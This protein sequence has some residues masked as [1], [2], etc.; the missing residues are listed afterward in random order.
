MSLQRDHG[1]SEERGRRTGFLYSKAFLEDLAGT[2][3][4]ALHPRF[5]EMLRYLEQVKPAGL[6]PGRQHIDPVDFPQFLSLIN[7]VDVEYVHG[8]RR[9]RFRL[10][11]TVQTAMAG[12]DVTG[13]PVDRAVLPSQALR[14]TGNMELAA[15]SGRPVYDRFPMPHPDRQF[16][17][18]ERVYYPLAA[19][20]RNVD[21]LL[22][23]NGYF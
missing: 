3:P 12:R 6:L 10:V 5:D 21:L 17:D 23:L 19:D 7:L 11:G 16:I 22:I 2:P 9:F 20:G 13:M 4:P 15:Q 1:R 18:S 14:I 8:H